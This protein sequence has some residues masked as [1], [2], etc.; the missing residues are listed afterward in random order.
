MK[1]VLL[2]LSVVAAMAASSLSAVEY[3]YEITPTVGGVMP[4]GNLDIDDQLYFGLIFG[5]RISDAWFDQFQLGVEYAPGVDYD[6]GNE[7]TGIIRGTLNFVKYF[8]ITDSFSIYGLVGF[9]GE[10]LTNNQFG[11]NNRFFVDY[12]AGLKY[13]FT[14]Q[15]ALKLEARHGI[16][17]NASPENS[18]QNNLFYS[19]GLS[20]AFGEVSAAPAPVKE[21][22]VEEVVVKEV[23][24]GDD[25]GDGVLNSVDECPNTPA[26]VPVDAKGCPLTISLHVNFNF[27]KANVLPKY[28]PEV[29]K[30]AN[31]MSKYPVYKVML[32]GYTDSTGPEDYN[33]KLSDRRAAAVA[34]SLEKLGVSGDKISTAGYGESKPVASNK[35]K[36]GRAENRRV[37]AVFSY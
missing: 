14:D 11:N 35:T 34:K 17:L 28:I 30:V 15:L 16:K 24:D 27:D 19:L 26:G 29:K 7:D 8:P 4:E 3:E 22:V 31:F 18:T 37:D 25:D 13:N 9:G 10:H 1:K 32:E 36:E 6:I 20:Y 23:K 21:E 12:G 33:M 2:T 5:K